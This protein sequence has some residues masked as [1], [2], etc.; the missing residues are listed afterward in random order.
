MKKIL[1]FVFVFCFFAIAA[2][3]D[4]DTPTNT[5]TPTDTATDTATSTA[6]YTATDT[7]TSTATPNMTQTAQV[8]ATATAIAQATAT[9]IPQ[10]STRQVLQPVPGSG[11]ITLYESAKP[12]FLKISP[13]KWQS[14]MIDYIAN[15]ATPISLYDGTRL[16]RYIS[17]PY[18]PFEIQ[19]DDM[20]VEKMIIDYGTNT[21][22]SNA[23]FKK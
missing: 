16:L 8:N 12:A 20:A 14:I 4:T 21:G 10:A 13:L 2:F 1:I 5:A 6:T 3:A 11:S 23:K 9:A 18:A 19:M 22:T 17:I 15:T 7:A